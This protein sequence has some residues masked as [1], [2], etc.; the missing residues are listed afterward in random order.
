MQ[1]RCS[2]T[3]AELRPA[4]LRLLVCVA[5]LAS[6]AAAQPPPLPSEA[7]TLTLASQS[8]IYQPGDTLDIQVGLDPAPLGY[9]GFLQVDVAL[10]PA[11]GGAAVWSGQQQATL[12]Q[13]TSLAFTTPAPT[14]DGAYWLTA[15]VAAPGAFRT[16]MLAGGARS[17]GDC[18]RQVLVMSSG[19]PLRPTTNWRPVAE[20][21]PT[22]HRWWERSPDWLRTRRLAWFSDGPLSFGALRPV[23]LDGRRFIE[24]PAGDAGP[25]AAWQLVPLSIRDVGAPHLLEVETP[26]GV[27]QSLTLS[28]V[29]PDAS[30]RLVPAGASVMHVTAATDVGRE[31]A[32]A[33]RLF[34]PRT[35]QPLLL[36]SNGSNDAP[37]HFATV[38]V[39]RA[40]EAPREA[41][42][43]SAR[44][45]VLDA[46]ADSAAGDFMV[47]NAIDW[48]AAFAGAKSLADLVELKGANT[49]IVRGPTGGDDAWWAA[50]LKEFDRRGLRLIANL[51]GVEAAAASQNDET[52]RRVRE[53]TD[54]FGHE[55]AVAG[56]ALE[57]NSSAESLA[58]LPSETQLDGFLKDSKLTWPD[59]APRDEDTVRAALTGPW[60][61]A[62]Q[63]W[64]AAQVTRHFQSI[65]SSLTAADKD[66]RLYLRAGP[67]LAEPAVAARLRP[68][69]N[70]S[71]SAA[72]ILLEHGV[73]IESLSCA[74]GI[75][76][77]LPDQLGTFGLASRPALQRQ[78][79]VAVGSQ[80]A[81]AAFD[82]PMRIVR[83][84]SFE[85]ARGCPDCTLRCVV[86]TSDRRERLAM[87][88][89]AAERDAVALV[90][91]APAIDFS[92]DE[93]E[94]RS[95]LLFGAL[96]P[97]G[98]SDAA[99]SQPVYVRTHATVVGQI[100]VFS[101][102][103]PWPVRATTTLSNTIDCEAAEVKPW[104][105][106]APMASRLK[107]GQHVFD[108]DL[109]PF[110]SRM[111]AI[112]DPDASVVGLRTTAPVGAE[113]E[114]RGRL[115]D[116]KRRDLNARRP[117]DAPVDPGFELTLADGAPSAWDS[118]V[119][120]SGRVSTVTDR[121]LSGLRALRLESQGEPITVASKPFPIPETGQL[122][123]QF[124]VRPI[125]LDDAARV[126]IAFDSVNGA[127]HS[128]TSIAAEG[129]R[130]DAQR[131]EW[132]AYVFGVDDLPIGGGEMQISLQCVGSASVDIDDLRSYSLFFPMESF[133]E[134]KWQRLALVR[135]V[136]SAE[137]ALD[138]GRYT[139]CLQILDGYW[140]SFVTAYTP[141]LP[142]PVA[143]AP[144]EAKQ[145]ET[146]PEVSTPTLG[147]RLRGWTPGFWR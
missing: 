81:V 102:A 12:G 17:L 143:S 35:T 78:T 141:R 94:R 111:L 87:A 62:W 54:Q 16:R 101:N 74:A 69:L 70:A 22:A 132:P 52:E 131:N 23:V 19:P 134:T 61:M 9:T 123:V 91:S 41:G 95:R 13:V 92:L 75:H 88:R 121:P 38:R 6:L 127:Y 45:V 24:V 18:R 59:S 114:L 113:A 26:I 39:L 126:V 89:V 140:P 99:T 8:P 51:Q 142:D 7:V 66:A 63:A 56:I 139:E 31:A 49:A 67:L 11:A 133:P 76:L 85:Q 117:L 104:D 128:A 20:I 30:G 10:T 3:C 72:G 25:D 48:H 83:L 97:A 122:V 50:V 135:M 119:Y 43:A 33:R 68:R 107:Q 144:T 98:D 137:V 34:W 130:S 27:S 86:R 112:G 28:V 4:T 118:A 65:A 58:S 80:L 120:P 64:R 79:E 105:A 125:D 129:L 108:F 40:G 136:Q 47:R 60:R 29:E 42:A 82:R 53:F 115:E 100:V 124:A 106:A 5:A 103:S 109:K 73:D 32:A 37:A 116:L 146:S 36:I 145:S 110:E 138:E 21:D 90:E 77:V 55:D 96:P 2:L 1:Y 147:E 71:A 14:K 44:P 93:L 57:L 46:S 84:A 15:T